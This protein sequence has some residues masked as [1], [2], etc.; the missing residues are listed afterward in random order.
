MQV[1]ERND[2]LNLPI[3]SASALNYLSWREQTRVFEGLAAIG[4]GTFTLS[5]HGDPENYTGNCDHAVI[6]AAAG[7]VADAGARVRRWGRQSRRRARRHDQRVALATSLRIERVGRRPYR[8]VQR[9][10]LHSRRHRATRVDDPHARRRLDPAGHRSAEGNPPQSRAVRRRTV[11]AG[12]DRSGGAGRNGRDRG[13]ASGSSIPRS[14]I[15][16][17]GW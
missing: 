14:R 5:G 17:S 11:E 12:R 15:G 8:H 4:F 13:D 16:A 3:F 7:R 10:R 9:H 1:A 2:K 6:A